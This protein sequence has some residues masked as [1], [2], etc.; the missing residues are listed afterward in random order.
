MSPLELS[1]KYFAVIG[2]TSGIGKATALALHERGATVVIHGPEQQPSEHIEELL[3]TSSRFNYIGGNLASDQEL[4]SVVSA[5]KGKIPR[6]D[7]LV[8][9]AAVTSHLDWEKVSIQEWDR[10]LRINTSAFLLLS[11]GCAPL[12]RESK[13]SIVAIS[14]TNGERVNHK[15][16]VYDVSKAALNHLIRALAL[17]LKNDGVRVN[18][19]APGGVDTPLLREWLVDYA[20]SHENAEQVLAESKS[21][22]AVAKPESIADVILFLLSHQAHWITG[23]IITADFGASLHS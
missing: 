18:G 16:L 11:Q 7:G 12:L 23:E 10:T 19:V 21:K 3:S 4:H 22:G 5:I 14:S 6:L 13:G 9:A 8:Y 17:E 2:S 1:E 15:N 20:G